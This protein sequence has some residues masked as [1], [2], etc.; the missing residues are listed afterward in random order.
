MNKTFRETRTFIADLRPMML[1]DLGLIPTLKRFVSSW[2]ARTEI[3]AD[4]TTVGKGHRLA[5]YVEVTI[6][7]AVQELM[8]NAAQHAN[9]SHVQVSL[10]LD[11]EMARAIVEDDGVGLD[12]EEVM[13]AAG[14]RKTIGIAAIM[15]QAQMLGGSLRY[16]SAPGRGTKAILQVPEN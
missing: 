2:S 7:R 10:E 4:C 11:G 1:D 14:A 9:P 8:K 13:A 3:P 16:D 12:I 5:P 6:F 15:D